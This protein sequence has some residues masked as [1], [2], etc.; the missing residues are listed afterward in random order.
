[1][2]CATPDKSTCS[3]GSVAGPTPCDWRTGQTNFPYG[4]EV[5]PANPFRAPGNAEEPATNGTSG[6]R[7]SGSSASAAL[8]LCLASRLAV[9]LDANGSPEYVLTWKRQ[10]M[11]SGP[12]ICAL[13]ASARRTSDNG[14]SGWPTPEASR[15]A[16][17]TD[18]TLSGDD[19][20]T[21][22]KL[23]WAASLA[24]WPTPMAGTPATDEYN[25]AGNTDSS[26]KTVALV[27]GWPT[28]RAEEREQYNSRD[29]YEAL[30]LKVRGL[31][32]SSLTVP[33]AK[34]GA[35]NPAFVRWLMG[36]PAEWDA[37]GP[38]ATRSSRRLQRRSSE[39]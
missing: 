3:P 2:S 11:P 8:Q 27:T 14:C 24:G 20:S 7:C 31:Q 28:P 39:V 6:P 37:C 10:P 23:G 38:T 35:L 26:R 30:S 13:R 16:N 4:P 12:P 29:G 18:T 19:R 21:P 32:A 36:F 5:V 34:R 9:A 25:E 22:N 17:R 15:V 33:T 1:M